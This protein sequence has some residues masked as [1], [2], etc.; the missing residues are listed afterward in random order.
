MLLK[1]RGIQ[2]Y[3]QQEILFR[4][5]KLN[6]ENSQNFCIVNHEHKTVH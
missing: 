2:L 5:E 4:I 6:E 3:K 1:N